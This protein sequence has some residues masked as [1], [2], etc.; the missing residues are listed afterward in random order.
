M[1]LRKVGRAKDWFLELLEL[2]DIIVKQIIHGK[3][4]E[5]NNPICF[6]PLPLKETLFWFGKQLNL[7]NFRVTFW[8]FSTWKGPK[9]KWPN[10]KDVI[11]LLYGHLLVIVPNK[12]FTKDIVIYHTIHGTTP[13]GWVFCQVHFSCL[14]TCLCGI[15]KST[16]HYFT[17]FHLHFAKLP[18]LPNCESQHYPI[19]KLTIPCPHSQVANSTLLFC[20]IVKCTSF[21][22]LPEWSFKLPTKKKFNF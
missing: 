17:E 19:P 6:F 13:N 5:H 15:A 22:G 7:I 12:S 20:Q 11:V 8:A 14:A 3:S 2:K 10:S 4:W 9:K 18:L 16:F 1:E 21:Y